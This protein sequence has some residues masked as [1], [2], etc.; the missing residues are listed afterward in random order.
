MRSTQ[1]QKQTNQETQV[2]PV[3]D[4]VAVSE[5]RIWLRQIFFNERLNQWQLMLALVRGEPNLRYINICWCLIKNRRLFLVWWCFILALAFVIMLFVVHLLLWWI[6]LRANTNS[7][8]SMSHDLKRRR[9]PHPEAEKPPSS[10]SK[11]YYSAILFV[12]VRFFFCALI[13]VQHVAAPKK[14]RRCLYC[15]VLCLSSSLDNP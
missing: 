3:V 15:I 12:S 13:F 6:A 8:P 10:P 2:G 7:S 4:E 14:Q 1:K 5:H 11:R 9:K